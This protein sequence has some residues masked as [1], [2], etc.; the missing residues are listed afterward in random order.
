M[1]MV[2]NVLG[3]IGGACLMVAAVGI[4]VLIW[5]AR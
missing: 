5:R 4:V 3:L 2:A 1:L